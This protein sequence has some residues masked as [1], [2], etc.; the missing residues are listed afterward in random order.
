MHHAP[1]VSHCW[2]IE[3]CSCCRDG[4]FF[5]LPID[6]S[7]ETLVDAFIMMMSSTTNNCSIIRCRWWRR[8]CHDCWRA[9]CLCLALWRPM[10]MAH[11]V[12]Q[13]V[14]LVTIG[15]EG[16]AVDD[17][18]S[19]MLATTEDGASSASIAYVDA[20]EATAGMS[21]ET[22]GVRGVGGRCSIAL[23]RAPM[24]AVDWYRWR[25]RA[26]MDDHHCKACSSTCACKTWCAS[27][28]R[29]F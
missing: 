16:V 26:P 29:T 24:V 10:W 9:R 14:C 7:G 4:F 18:A 5:C 8:R 20:D 22:G 17:G 12:S 13:L 23:R 6:A 15:V 25:R 11:A 1:C 21:T 28:L 3:L 27:I 2:S 19:T